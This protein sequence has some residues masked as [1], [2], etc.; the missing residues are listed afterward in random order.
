MSEDGDELKVLIS[1]I[2][3]GVDITDLCLFLESDKYGGGFLIEHTFDEKCRTALV[4]F[5]DNAVA[6]RLLKEG[7]FVVESVGTFTVSL[8]D[9]SASCDPSS[10]GGDM[11][12]GI[13][14]VLVENVPADLHGYLEVVLEE[15]SGGKVVSCTPDKRHKG[16]LIELDKTEAAEKLLARGH[17][18]FNECKVKVSLPPQPDDS[19]FRKVVVRGIPSQLSTTLLKKVFE[20]SK[21]DGGSVE[22]I[23]REAGK[24]TA[25]VTFKEK[26][27]AERLLEAGKVTVGRDCLLLSRPLQEEGSDD[28]ELDQ[29]DT[30]NANTVEVRNLPCQLL[31]EAMLKLFFE[32]KRQSGGG[33][34]EHITMDTIRKVAVIVFSD[35]K[36]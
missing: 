10:D 1:D 17:I 31:E 23:D 28:E 26:Q 16:V 14:S 24:D 32:N 9:T 33:D 34:I 6:K 3:A 22:S 25:T 11:Q 13:R 12:H 35:P 21:V 27:V 18:E 20:S 5:E 4:T 29:E 19:S 7:K 15:E 30:K 8:P 2:P 36:G